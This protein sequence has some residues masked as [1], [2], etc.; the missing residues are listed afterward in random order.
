MATM[1]RLG[2][3]VVVGVIAI[4]CKDGATGPV[5]DGAPDVS[6]TDLA[7]EAPGGGDGPA[8]DAPAVACGTET[9]GPAQAC[10]RVCSCGGVS[11]ACMPPPDG[12]AC[13]AGTIN[14]V[15]PGGAA[16]CSPTCMNPPPRCED[17]PVSCAGVVASR[18]RNISCA[19]PP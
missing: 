12:G 9:C 11:P 3:L 5:G 4:G 13:P 6:G 16:G 8:S 14:C 10:V 2:L 1:T 17:L 7:A 18:E 15:A 19:C